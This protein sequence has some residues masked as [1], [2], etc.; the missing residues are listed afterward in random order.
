MNQEQK[1]VLVL[2]EWQR[3]VAAW[4][5]KNFGDPC[6]PMHMMLGVVEEL[7]ELAH[8]LLKQ[9]QGVRGT[10]EENEHKA[11]DAVGD[12]EIFLAGLCTARGWNFGELVDAAWQSVQK[13]DWQRY[14]ETG[15]PE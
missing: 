14:K 1:L 4:R 7:G 10:S 8:A 3:E 6:D 13:R 2:D 11:K 9:A 5:S 15:Q 12:I